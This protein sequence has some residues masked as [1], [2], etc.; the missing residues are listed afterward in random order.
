MPKPLN[1]AGHKFN[2]LQA[3][4]LASKGTT[5]RKWLCRCECGNEVIVTTGHLRSG[6]SKSCGCLSAEVLQTRNFK[7]G[8]GSRAH[9][10]R[11]YYAWKE[12]KKR[13]YQT[14]SK[15][16]K[17]YGAK[18]ITVCSEWVNDFPKFFADMGLCPEGYELDR[19]DG[20]K[21]YSKANCRWVSEAM[22]SRN[23]SYVKLTYELAEQIRSDSRP[24]TQIAKDYG[25]SK[26]TILNIKRYK[27]WKP[28]LNKTIKLDE[29]A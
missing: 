16:Y 17:W 6:H 4:S 13:C 10:T 1:I 24:S 18:G 22:Q 7:H 3:I 15:N 19:I 14:N 12:M 20:T 2:R 11:E 9:K 8:Q 29:V 21:G 28:V 26:S 5:G 27:T 25:V 23:R